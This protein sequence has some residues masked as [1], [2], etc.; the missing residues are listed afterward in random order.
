[1][2]LSWCE[3]FCVLRKK[4]RTT[5]V[6]EFVSDRWFWSNE[7]EKTQ[8]R[9]RHCK[10]AGFL[11]E[12]AIWFMRVSPALTV[13]F[14][15]CAALCNRTEGLGSHPLSADE[16]LIPYF[17]AHKEEK[18][19]ILALVCLRSVRLSGK[20]ACK[21]KE[22]PVWL[23]INKSIPNWNILMLGQRSRIVFEEFPAVTIVTVHP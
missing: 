19:L 21:G 15:D 4:K 8:L 6:T 7:S 22:Q 5:N 3:D 9:W 23:C 11:W 18:G 10:N 12:R 1:M 17:H 16:G 2:W 13:F 20:S 14:S